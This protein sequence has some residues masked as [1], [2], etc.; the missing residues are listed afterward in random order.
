MYAIL[1]F[2]GIAENLSELGTVPGQSRDMALGV[3]GRDCE[4]EFLQAA[5]GNSGLSSSY[6][7]PD[8]VAKAFI[9]SSEA[10]ARKS[11]L[12]VKTVSGWWAF[13][14]TANRKITMICALRH[15]DM[16]MRCI[17]GQRISAFMPAQV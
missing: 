17:A 4:G 16:G 12:K 5:I 1:L 9:K 7:V 8:P 13:Q 6:A 10:P 2:R 14:E 11:N 3:L 15:E